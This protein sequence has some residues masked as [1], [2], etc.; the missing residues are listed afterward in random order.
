[1][2]SEME[3]RLGV[4]LAGRILPKHPIIVSD[5]HTGI[6]GRFFFNLALVEDEQIT[7]SGYA[8]LGPDDITLGA[9]G[10]ETVAV[11]VQLSPKTFLHTP[12]T[13][14]PWSKLLIFLGPRLRQPIADVFPDESTKKSEAWIIS[15]IHKSL[16]EIGALQEA[17]TQKEAV[18]KFSKLFQSHGF[19]VNPVF[20][21]HLRFEQGLEDHR[22]MRDYKFFGLAGE[23]DIGELTERDLQGVLAQSNG[24]KQLEIVRPDDEGGKLEYSLI[25]GWKGGTIIMLPQVEMLPA[26]AERP[27]QNVGQIFIY[28]HF[29]EINFT[30]EERS[31]FST[32]DFISKKFQ[33]AYVLAIKATD[34]A[35][36]ASYIS[37]RNNLA[38]PDSLVKIKWD[39]AFA[40]TQENYVA[41]MVWAARWSLA[42]AS[43][44]HPE[45]VVKAGIFIADAGPLPF[46]NPETVAKEFKAALAADGAPRVVQA[47]A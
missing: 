28:N 14:A 31:A 21:S 4:N 34:E 30:T 22:L 16:E 38:V 42:K 32:A 6:V 33:P 12:Q 35:I 13:G 45:E 9:D 19:K 26:W 44:I 27:I 29:E 2:T 23:G 43:S 25:S 24:V 8:P 3:L 46:I 17:L 11:T 37:R 10:V 5:P 20:F 41:R 1:M 18:D 47:G 15:E 40:P 7:A 39:W 36:E